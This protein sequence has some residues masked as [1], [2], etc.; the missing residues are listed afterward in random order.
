M[1]QNQDPPVAVPSSGHPSLFGVTMLLVNDGDRQWVQQK[2]RSPNE[3]DPVLAEIALCFKRVPFKS[4]AQLSPAVWSK[5]C[6]TQDEPED[7]QVG[8]G[9]NAGECKS[10]CSMPN[11][12]PWP[13]CQ[14]FSAP[15]T[16]SASPAP[17]ASRFMAWSKASCALKSTWVCQEKTRESCAAIW[18]RSAGSAKRKSPV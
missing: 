4:V 6:P 18:S 5:S 2:L 1:D 12:S 17:A 3:A 8:S 14:S 13:R 7:D 9:H 11:V 15:A 16:I 10:P